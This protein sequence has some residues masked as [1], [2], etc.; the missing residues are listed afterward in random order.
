MCVFFPS[1][2]NR[3]ESLEDGSYPS[4]GQIQAMMQQDI[5]FLAREM[6]I[7]IPE[8]YGYQTIE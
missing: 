3:F 6:T 2:L 1:I 4:F 8:M 7:V 5:D